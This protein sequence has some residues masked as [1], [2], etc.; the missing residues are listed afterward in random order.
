MD[1]VK[2]LKFPHASCAV[3]SNAFGA[4]G[5]MLIQ[6]SYVLICFQCHVKAIKEIV[7]A[8]ESVLAHK[9]RNEDL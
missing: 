5:S 2:I 6:D 4:M 7:D 8:Y 1:E 9:E 3:C